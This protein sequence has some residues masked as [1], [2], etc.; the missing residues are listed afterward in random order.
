MITILALRFGRQV[1]ES[2]IAPLWLAV[3]LLV[4]GVGGTTGLGVALPISVLAANIPQ[5]RVACKEGNLTDLPWGTRL[6]SMADGLVWGSYTLF[7]QDVAILV[8]AGFQLT[9]SGLIVVLKLA[10]TANHAKQRL[11]A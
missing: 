11:G 1:R 3:L 6:L 5:L 10:H 8:F 2:R 9:T 4:G 7:Q